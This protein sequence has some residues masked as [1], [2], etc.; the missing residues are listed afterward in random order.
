M[1]NVLPLTCVYSS[2]AISLYFSFTH[3][4]SKSAAW[5]CQCRGDSQG[6][7]RDEDVRGRQSRAPSRV[8]KGKSTK[9]AAKQTVTKPPR[10]AKATRP[11]YRTMNWQEYFAIRQYDWYEKVPRDEHIDDPNFWC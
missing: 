8:E 9:G 6:S 5:K 1:Y 3:G 7:E 10:G 11:N 4:S 2:T